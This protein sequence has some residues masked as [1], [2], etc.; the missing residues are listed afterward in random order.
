MKY[1]IARRAVCCAIT[2]AISVLMLATSARAQ[3]QSG[4]VWQKIDPTQISDNPVTLFSQDWMALAAGQ[5]GNMNAMTIAWGGLGTLWGMNNAAVVT[6][7]V[8]PSRYTHQFMEKN[9]YFTVTTFPEQYKKALQYIGSRSGRNEDKI[10]N[11]GLS[12]SFTELGN[13][14]FNEA[15]LAIECRKIYAAPFDPAGM[16]EKGRRI[17]SGNSGMRPHTIFI[18]EIVNVWRKQ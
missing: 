14:I 10:A 4:G 11:A 2:I 18:G 15:R 6:V 8:E 13:P 16:G 7:Y 3:E 5:P 9:E 1:F 17:Y 12:V